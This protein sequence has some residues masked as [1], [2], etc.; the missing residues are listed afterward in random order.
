MID[1]NI[2]RADKQYFIAI[3]FIG[4]NEQRIYC[5]ANYCN[6]ALGSTSCVNVMEFIDIINKYGVLNYSMDER[7]LPKYSQ[8]SEEK[9]RMTEESGYTQRY[10]ILTRYLEKEK[11][12]GFDILHVTLQVVNG[13]LEGKSQLMRASYSDTVRMMRV[14]RTKF[15][16]AEMS[17]NEVIAAIKGSFLKR[18]IPERRGLSKTE[19]DKVILPNLSNGK[20]NDSS[21]KGILKAAINTIDSH[22]DS[23][24]E[25]NKF[26]RQQE[27]KRLYS[28]YVNMSDKELAGQYQNNATM[29]IIRK[30]LQNGRYKTKIKSVLAIGIVCATLGGI[31]GNMAGLINYMPENRIEIK[32][33]SVKPKGIAETLAAIEAADS[34]TVDYDI[35]WASGRVFADGVEVAVLKSKTL[36]VLDS[37]QL[38]TLDGETIASSKQKISIFGKFNMVGTDGETSKVRGHISLLGVNLEHVDDNGNTLNTIKSSG[39]TL[40]T[41]AN[42]KDANGSNIFKVTKEP[43][44]KTFTLEKTGKASELSNSDALILSGL[45][46]IRADLNSRSTSSGGSS[47]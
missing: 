18:Q 19:V 7:W 23:E 13:K 27:Y 46:I 33:D 4:D 41:K 43:F 3:G 37:V 47:K 15:I 2:I 35:N 32:K 40:Y 20:L 21:D 16:N 45:T 6:G 9:L 1:F 29:G 25:Q 26:L 31:T 38:K 28:T 12:V 8:G 34:I 22:I 36:A 17:Q 44:G 24:P 42:I 14:N 5:V 10:F 30:G 39:L 11:T